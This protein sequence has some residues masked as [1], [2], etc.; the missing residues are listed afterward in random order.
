MTNM[1]S[2]GRPKT[3]KAIETLKFTT[4]Q[5]ELTMFKNGLIDSLDDEENEDQF[6]KETVKKFLNMEV[7]R[8]NIFIVYLLNKHSK[9]TFKEL[10]NLLQ[11]DRVELRR[12]IVAIKNE[13][14]EI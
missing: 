2:K 12:A 1:N 5:E 11:V 8:Q 10:A 14:Q 13:L 9:F 7:W 4:Y 3:V 6:S